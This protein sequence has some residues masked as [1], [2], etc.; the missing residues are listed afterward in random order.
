MLPAPC[1]GVRAVKS[2]WPPPF[3]TSPKCTFL[4]TPPQSLRTWT[5]YN[6]IGAL[7]PSS[8]PGKAVCTSI[9]CTDP[10]L[11][12]CPS[13]GEGSTARDFNLSQH[14]HSWMPTAGL[15]VPS[16]GTETD[17][18]AL[19][20][21]P[22]PAAPSAPSLRGVGACR[23]AKGG[24]ETPTPSSLLLSFPAGPSD[25]DSLPS[26]PG[27]SAHSRRPQ[28]Q[29]GGQTG[30]QRQAQLTPL[31]CFLAGR[32]PLPLHTFPCSPPL[33]LPTSVPQSIG[34]SVLPQPL[35]EPFHTREVWDLGAEPQIS[36]S[37]RK[38]PRYRASGGN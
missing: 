21:T 22:A 7:S 3:P 5:P 2:S 26:S 25:S 16:F 23:D 17:P 27:F 37:C 10:C 28:Q 14:F 11:H 29:D 31:P 36:T 15:L 24:A 18:I 12:P 34:T 13:P 19:P 33:I 20:P 6:V 38:F 35:P 8:R 9:C 32:L 4:P 30:E 1:C